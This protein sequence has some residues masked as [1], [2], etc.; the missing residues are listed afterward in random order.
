MII[1][2]QEL[3]GNYNRFNIVG[4]DFIIIP[5]QELPGNY[6]FHSGGLCT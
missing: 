6:N 5:Y 3:P 4:I 2:Y 1:P